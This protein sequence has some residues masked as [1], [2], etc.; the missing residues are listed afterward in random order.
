M[1]ELQTEEW[2]VTGRR[3]I[4]RYE[5]DPEMAPAL[6]I[7]RRIGVT[8]KCPL[9]H[10]MPVEVTADETVVRGTAKTGVTLACEKCKTNY[11]LYLGEWPSRFPSDA[12]AKKSSPFDG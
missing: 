8:A 10:E 11:T 6:R 9:G 4:V 2:S 12:V 3:P 1:S 5:V 7:D